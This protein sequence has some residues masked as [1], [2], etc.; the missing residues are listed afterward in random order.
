VLSAPGSAVGGALTAVIFAV[1]FWLRH[2][3]G[4]GEKLRLTI[5][6]AGV[7]LFVA[8]P[9]LLHVLGTGAGTF[10]TAFANE[11]RTESLTG[12]TP[13][14]RLWSLVTDFPLVYPQVFLWQL[15]VGIGL[16]AAAAH[17]RARPA[18]LWTLAVFVL[19]PREGR[20]LVAPGLA[21]LALLA[22]QTL[23]E[24]ARR[25]LPRES[26]AWTACVVLL[27][28]LFALFPYGSPLRAAYGDYTS[29]AQAASLRDNAFS[30]FGWLRD[31]TPEHARVLVVTNDHTLEQAPHEAHRTVINVLW[32]SEFEPAKWNRIVRTN[33]ELFT[34]AGTA[35]AC[36]LEALRALDARMM[37]LYVLAD[38]TWL[39]ERSGP[40]EGLI[41]LH[42]EGELSIFRLWPEPE[43]AQ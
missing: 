32:G 25:R 28:L 2:G 6:A 7:S 40:S 14:S 17:P 22:V 30:A 37:P 42:V 10:A 29:F 33:R 12:A 31:H 13:L 26:R 4:P 18:A 15:L 3:A 36:V 23:F 24:E 21:F 41:L 5:A 1:W 8:A 38:S 39:E 16:L 34:C 43:I 20:W 9:W 27:V 35:E 11:M 19:V